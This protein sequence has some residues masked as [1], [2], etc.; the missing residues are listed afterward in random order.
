[1]EVC[2][3]QAAPPPPDELMLIVQVDPTAPGA[4][5]LA[6]GASCRH[7]PLPGTLLRLLTVACLPAQAH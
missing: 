3:G 1:M 6:Q 7:P 4:D 5:T 2:E